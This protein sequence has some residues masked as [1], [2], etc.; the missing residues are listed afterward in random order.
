VGIAFNLFQPWAMNQDG[1]DEETLN[2]T[3]RHEL[4]GY[5][6]RAF[7][8][9]PNLVDFVSVNPNSA[10]QVRYVQGFFQVREDPTHPGQYLGVDGPEFGFHATG[11]VLRVVAPP[12]LDADQ[13]HVEAVT[14]PDT[15]GATPT[16]AHTGRYRSPTVLSDGTFLCVH[17]AEIGQD[18][19]DGTTATPT[20]RYDFRLKTMTFDGAYFEAG[21]PLTPGLQASVSWWS[22]DVFTT[23]SGTLWEL[24]PVEVVARPVPPATKAAAVPA[25][26]AA[27]FAQ[28]GVTASSVSSWLAAN[29]LALIVSRDV[30]TRDRSDRQQPF[31]LKVSGTAKQTLGASGKVYDVSYLQIVQGDLVRGLGKQHV[32]LPAGRRVLARFLHDPAVDHPAP[33]DGSAP[34]GSVEVE[35]DGSVAAL[36]PARRAVSWQLVDETGE[37]VV[38]ERYWV[39]FQPGE[40]RVCASCHGA[41]QKDQAGNPPPTNPPK[42][43]KRLLEHLKAKGKL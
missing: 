20:S 38:Q 15:S 9:D 13:V 31:N 27:V 18:Q 8:D 5:V 22:P 36:V 28:A 25:P 34:E 4:A 41:N 19:N 40:V 12:G 33:T 10:N 42:A 3:G 7:H 43:L 39:T 32:P 6:D 1:T 17:S 35:D 37:P 29:E 30:T 23:W 11:R 26:E 2:H 21:A 14:H 16:P 24:D